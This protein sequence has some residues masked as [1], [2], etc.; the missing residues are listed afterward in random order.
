MIA[1][2][3]RAWHPIVD[4]LVL[5]KEHAKWNML[6]YRRRRLVIDQAV[7]RILDAKGS[8]VRDKKARAVIFGMGNAAFKSRGPKKKIIQA[9][10]RGMKAL[11]AEGRPAF[12][13]FIDEYNTTKKCHRCLGETV[14]PKKK[15]SAELRSSRSVCGLPQPTTNKRFKVEDHRFRDCS[16]CG[17]QTTPKRWGRVAAKPRRQGLRPAPLERSFEHPEEAVGVTRWHGGALATSTTGQ[18]RRSAAKQCSLM[19]SCQSVGQARK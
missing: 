11:R 3:A 2:Q 6:L 19:F 9:L 5:D 18:H 16:H 17:D 12:L 7:R 15:I 13:V 1:A 4:E 10:I 14:S 8:H